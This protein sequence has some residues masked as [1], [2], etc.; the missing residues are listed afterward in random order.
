VGLAA[1][2]EAVG[3]GC[4]PGFWRGLVASVPGAMDLIRLAQTDMPACP[5]TARRLMATFHA[6]LLLPLRALFE[7]AVGRTCR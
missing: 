5:E 2:I 7:E 3:V 6:S 4:A 1:A